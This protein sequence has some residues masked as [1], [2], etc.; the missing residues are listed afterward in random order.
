[1]IEIAVLVSEHIAAFHA[2]DTERVL[3]GLA[4]DAVWITGADTV[5]GKAARCWTSSTINP[6]RC[7]RR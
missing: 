1:M 5:R 2:H 4:D 6:G 7:R 3:A